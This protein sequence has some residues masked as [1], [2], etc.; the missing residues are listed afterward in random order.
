M[1]REIKFNELKLNPRLLLCM[2]LVSL[3]FT[4]VQAEQ[5]SQSAQQYISP[6]LQLGIHTQAT[7][8]SPI[9]QLISSGMAVEVLAVDK[10]FS[11][12]KTADSIEGWV[13]SK[14]LTTNEP[15]AMLLEKMRQQKAQR[16]K[17]QVA[18]AGAEAVAQSATDACESQALA[19]PSVNDSPGEDEKAVYEA[20]IAALKEEIKAWEQLDRQDKKTLQA[21]AEKANRQLK[22]KLAMIASVAI[23][24]DVDASQFD[25]TVKGELPQIKH[26]PNQTLMKAVNKNLLLLLMVAGLS[27]FI[28]VFIM[29][30]I[31]RRRHGG[32][33]V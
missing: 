25:L 11:R 23:G 16:E 32:Y 26:A 22:E 21:Q 33:R 20:Q 10:D 27:F 3:L 30:L 2:V 17:Q 8:E 6:R 7:L 19:A 9:K 29:D 4:S 1:N 24:Q 28:G 31:N 13:K 15:A 5:A 18:Q 14:F 12:I